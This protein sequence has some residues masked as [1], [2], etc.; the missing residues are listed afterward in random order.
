M[1]KAINKTSISISIDPKVL[2]MLD[3]KTSN[4]SNYIDNI[5]LKYFN[6]SLPYNINTFLD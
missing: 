3:N 4:R 6:N 1:K 5:L 2:Y